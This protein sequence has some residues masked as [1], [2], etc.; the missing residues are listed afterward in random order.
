[1]HRMNGFGRGE[2]SQ[3][4]GA[5]GFVDAVIPAFSFSTANI[6]NQR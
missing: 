2:E 1:M 6:L 3:Q 5:N 4:A